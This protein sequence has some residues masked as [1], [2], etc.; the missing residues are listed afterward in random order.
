M[1]GSR[2]GW[3]DPSLLPAQPGL[4][5]WVWSPEQRLRAGHPFLL[6]LAPQ[7]WPSPLI[8]VLKLSPAES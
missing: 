7:M 5:S 4:A 2:C 1:L 8:A 3:Q 6:A